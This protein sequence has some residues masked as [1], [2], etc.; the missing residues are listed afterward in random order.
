[1]GR[2]LY[3]RATLLAASLSAAPV[4][5][6]ADEPPLVADLPEGLL[7]VGLVKAIELRIVAPDFFVEAGCV[8][9]F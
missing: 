4:L 6:A 9:R 5:A 3:T 7:R 1:M 2:S 8:R